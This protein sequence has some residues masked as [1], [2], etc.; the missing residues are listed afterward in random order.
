MS[1]FICRRIFY[2]SKEVSEVKTLFASA[3]IAMTLAA[4]TIGASAAGA[5]TPSPT[6]KAYGFHAFFKKT[7]TMETHRGWLVVCMNGHA[8][9]WLRSAHAA[10]ALAAAQSHRPSQAQGAGRPQGT[11]QGESGAV[12]FTCQ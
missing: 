4:G 10:N 9:P 7:I 2:A 8:K 12:T 3:I 1:V 5:S 6:G 11:T